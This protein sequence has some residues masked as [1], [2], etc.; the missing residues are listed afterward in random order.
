MID[1]IIKRDG[2]IVPFDRRKITFAILQAAVA[3]GGRDKKTAETVTD[4]VIRLLKRRAS[5]GTYPAVEEVQDLVEKCL[6]ERGH[7]KTAKAYILYRYEHALKR[8]GKKNPALLIFFT[9]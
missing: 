1:K 8:A 3:V 5:K 4:D 7:A 2:S 9:N 6:I